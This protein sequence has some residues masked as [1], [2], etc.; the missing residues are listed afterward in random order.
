MKKAIT[1]LLFIQFLCFYSIADSFSQDGKFPDR[2]SSNPERIL[3]L[4][5]LAQAYYDEGLFHGSVLVA[6]KGKIIF[7]KGYGYANYEWEIPNNPDT[8]FDLVSVSKQFTAMAIMILVD[9][10]KLDLDVPVSTY[11]PGFDNKIYNQ[12]T[13]RQL[14]SHTSGLTRSVLSPFEERKNTDLF[15]KEDLFSSLNNLEIYAEPGSKFIYSN[16]GY[17]VLSFIIEKL[18]GMEF[19]DYLQK[20]IFK[21]LNMTGSG[22]IHDNEIIKNL[23]SPYSNHI[24]EK[25]RVQHQN[26]SMYVRGAG[27][28]YSTVKDLFKWDQALYKNTLLTEGSAKSMFTAVQTNYGFGWNLSPL[29]LPNKEKVQRTWHSGRGPGASA[30]IHRFI[31]D[32]L[33]IVCLSNLEV[34]HTWNLSLG[35]SRILHDGSVKYPKPSYDKQLIEVLFSQGIDSAFN[36]Y[37]KELKNPNIRLPGPGDFIQIVDK[38]YSRYGDYAKSLEILKLVTRLFQSTAAGFGFYGD[39]LF[40]T[41][42]KELAIENYRKAIELDLNNLEAFEALQFLNVD[43][44]GEIVNPLF[45]EIFQKGPEKGLIK[46]QSLLETDNA[47]SEFHIYAVGM[48]LKRNNRISEAIKLF[49]FN[50]MA[51]PKSTDALDDLAK[52]YLDDGRKE[53]AIKTYQKILEIDPNMEVVKEVIEKLKKE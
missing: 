45:L 43:K 8:K 20:V 11:L 16:G 15:M 22:F 18:S 23:S 24:G 41:G 13:C 52:A 25:K 2:F 30:I 3:K 38:K 6:H 26:T 35:L 28:L 31:D 10:G 5:S 48:N 46:Y 32:S 50:V 42:E 21:P 1:L 19:P 7:E 40:K 49:E 17:S 9:E 51:F 4:D 34:A 33:L 14:L 47:P 37:L 12:I 53:L 44:P 36:L 29:K 27:R 39:I